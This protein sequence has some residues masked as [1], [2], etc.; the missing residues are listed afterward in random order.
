MNG[1]PA[2]DPTQQRVNPDVARAA[3]TENARKFEKALEAM[4]DEEGPVV[5]ALRAELKTAQ[6][7]AAVP[8]SNSANRSF[9]DRSD[10]WQ[11]WTNNGPQRKNF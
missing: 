1:R 7:A 11:S 8:T 6:S 3:A 5:D 10:A 9:R 2:T 4:S